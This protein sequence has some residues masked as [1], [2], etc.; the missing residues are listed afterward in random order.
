M[1]LGYYVG[2]VFNFDAD[3]GGFVFQGWAVFSP[4]GITGGRIFGSYAA[5]E[6][7]LKSFVAPDGSELEVLPRS[8]VELFPHEYSSYSDE[9][10]KCLLIGHI[11]TPEESDTSS[12]TASPRP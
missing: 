7:A 10:L 5:A 12:E 11:E 6:S 1:S 3:N 9:E 4:G 2:P 8:L